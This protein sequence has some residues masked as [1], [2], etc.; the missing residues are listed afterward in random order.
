MRCAQHQKNIKQ[1]GRDIAV[2]QFVIGRFHQKLGDSR[3]HSNY[4]YNKTALLRATGLLGG[5]APRRRGRATAARARGVGA[6]LRVVVVLGV[7]V[8][9]V[10]VGVGAARVGG[11]H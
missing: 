4:D 3:D 10:A 9:A 8:G 6:S 1:F 7:G 5:C 2:V 11:E